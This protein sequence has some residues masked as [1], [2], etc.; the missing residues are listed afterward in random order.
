MRGW[1]ISQ[2]WISEKV[3]EKHKDH[4][5]GRENWFKEDDGEN[6]KIKNICL[7]YS[8]S[9]SNSMASFF[10]FLFEY[11][12]FCISLLLLCLFWGVVC[13]F[14]CLFGCFLF[15]YLFVLYCVG[16][17]G[18]K[19]KSWDCRIIYFRFSWR[20]FFLFLSCYRFLF[21][22]L[23]HAV[24]W[25]NFFALFLQTEVKSSCVSFFFFFFFFDRNSRDRISVK[26]V[27]KKSE[28]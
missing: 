11:L 4:H 8:Y 7:V 6:Y 12:L 21:S 18:A 5:E 1:E 2:W 16:W 23:F 25:N 13:L 15:V 3:T 22:D 28:S 24:F 10:F 19:R 14:I 17:S 9:K 20:L 26:N 27:I